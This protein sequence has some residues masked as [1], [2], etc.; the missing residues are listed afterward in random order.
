MAERLTP[1]LTRQV[2]ALPMPDRVTLARIL[3]DSLVPAGPQRGTP[4][5][6][7]FLAGKM[8]GISG[9]DIHERTRRAEV[10]RARV[11]FSLVA[12][13]EGFTTT[14]IGKYLGLDHATI[15]HY[16][17]AM[18]DAFAVP[19]AWPEHIALYNEYINAIL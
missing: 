3:G 6:L 5:R 4:E 9:V 10:I 16:N 2:L 12:T 1:Y 18:R 17:K 15:V 8:A 13:N 7:E 11:V 19:N 14:N